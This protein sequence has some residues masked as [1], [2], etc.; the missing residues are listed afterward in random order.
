MLTTVK[1]PFLTAF[2][3]IVTLSLKN[4]SGTVAFRAK[5]YIFRG[6]HHISK[7]SLLEGLYQYRHLICNLNVDA[8][9]TEDCFSTVDFGQRLDLTKSL[10]AGRLTSVQSPFWL[11]LTSVQLLLLERLTSRTFAFLHS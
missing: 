10:F 6:K 1:S 5:D 2:I 8:F 7:I 3:C 9:C 11:R 4:P